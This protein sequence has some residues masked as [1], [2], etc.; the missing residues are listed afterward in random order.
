MNILLFLMQQFLFNNSL[1]QLNNIKIDLNA[2]LLQAHVL[3]WNWLK[4]S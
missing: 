4:T 1:F 3:S 2:Y